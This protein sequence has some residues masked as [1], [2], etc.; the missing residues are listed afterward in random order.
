VADSVVLVNTNPLWVGLLT[1]LISKE[2]IKLTTSVSILISI[3][4]AVII[5]AE[6]FTIGSETLTCSKVIGGALILSAICLVAYGEKPATLSD[7]R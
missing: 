6:D 5:G 2:K 3:L 1:P 7:S 4:G